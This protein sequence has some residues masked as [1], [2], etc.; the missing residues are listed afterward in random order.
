MISVRPNYFILMGY[1][2][3]MISVRPNY[4]IF[5]GYL[6]KMILVRSNYFIFMG[7][8]RKM[9]SVRPNCFILMGYLRKMRKI[10]KANPPYLCTKEPPFQKFWIC[11]CNNLGYVGQCQFS[12]CLRASL[13][14]KAVNHIKYII[15]FASNCH[16]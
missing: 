14:P 10:S 9:I 1:L 15:L 16:A 12:H 2:R 8:L 13:D 6:R 11:P 5:M 4:F 3:K 7:Y